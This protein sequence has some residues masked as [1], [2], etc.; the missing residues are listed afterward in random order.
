MSDITFK[1]KGAVRE[2]SVDL[3]AR[4]QTAREQTAL[5][6]DEVDAAMRRSTIKVPLKRDRKVVPCIVADE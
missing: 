3:E 6:D 4:E 1:E 5:Q 2:N